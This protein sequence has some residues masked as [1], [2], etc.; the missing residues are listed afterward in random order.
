MEVDTT[1]EPGA[2]ADAMN[3]H[4]IHISVCICT[5][6]R[7]DML[8]SLLSELRDQRTDGL[9]TYSIVVA[10]NDGFRSAEPVVAEFSSQSHMQVHYCV[11]PKQ[12]IALARNKALANAHGDFVAFIDDDEFPPKFWL[13]TLFNACSKYQVDGVL[14]PV[15]PHF[16]TEPPKWV[17]EGK[18]YERETYP[19]GLVIDWRKGRT[20]NVLFRK[21]LVANCPDPFKP[22][23]Q[24]GEDQDFF[25][26]L[27]DDGHV[28]M[29]CNEAVVFETVP[30]VR[31]KRG[32][33]VKRAL[34]RGATSLLHP[35]SGGRG[36]LKSLL[37]IGVY[38]VMLPFALALNHS[39]FMTLLVRM[40]DHIG[41]ILAFMKLNPIKQSY[42]TE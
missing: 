27:I 3:K 4:S 41:K 21:H 31:W 35:A 36:I 18:F 15:K 17:I 8:K 37:A 26:R 10:D 5:Y 22:E 2:N 11:E 30:P 23:F 1:C 28:F 19:T 38:S 13:L 32:F 29:W 9:F 14:G 24:T 42:I 7:Q 6:K 16:D 40:C 20:G 34:L 12:N 33:M 39:W 25:H